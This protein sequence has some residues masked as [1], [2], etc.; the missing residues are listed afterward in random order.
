MYLPFIIWISLHLP[1]HP[2]LQDEMNLYSD[3]IQNVLILGDSHLVGDFGEYLHRGMHLKGKFNIVSIGIG[4]A[5]SYHFTVTM[6]GF[7]CGYKIRESCWFDSIPEKSRIPV[8]EE[9]YGASN[10]IVGKF[11]KGKLSA[12]IAHYD[13]E[14]IIIALGSNYTN[15]HEELMSI[16]QKDDTDRKIIWVGPM[17]RSNIEMRLL[18]INQLIKKYPE[19]NF[20]HSEDIIGHDTITSAHYAGKPAKRWADE[21]INRM[22]KFINN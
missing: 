22:E 20:V 12:Y 9:G 17:R 13:P 15:A 3:S 6:R 1:F 14:I 11:F 7:C 8:T 19:I 2:K 21:V 18:A 10:Q 16:I 5:G 4:G